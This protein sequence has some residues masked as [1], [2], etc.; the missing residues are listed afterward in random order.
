MPGDTRERLR[1][2][3]WLH[4][5]D[6]EEIRWVSHPSRYT[7]AGSLAVAVVLVIV[8]AGLAG[9]VFSFAE[10]REVP[11]WAGFTPL[12]LTL[13]GV[14]R[15]A[16]TYVH[17]H[18]HVYVITD[19][20]VYVK[21]GLVSRSITQVPIERVQNSSF[22]QSF[23]QRLLSYGDV[24]VFTAGSSTKEVTLA[25][26]PDPEEVSETLTNTQTRQFSR[27]QKSRGAV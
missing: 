19:E 13:Y 24:H 4:L 26:V 6:D 11:N 9:V 22:D 14:V 15:G 17:W 12:V 18:H 1:A 20:A 2:T 8:G 5:T 10:G 23:L 16:K 21:Y 3:D 7:I 25:D 27:D